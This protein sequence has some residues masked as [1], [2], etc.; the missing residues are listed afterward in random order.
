MKIIKT[1]SGGTQIKMSRNEWLKIG[2]A[3]GWEPPYSTNQDKGT[4]VGKHSTALNGEWEVEPDITRR[5][6]TPS[7]GTAMSV[8]QNRFIYELKKLVIGGPEGSKWLTE[9]R[10]QAAIN[11]FNTRTN[12]MYTIDAVRQSNGDYAVIKG[13]EAS[14][15][16]EDALKE[17]R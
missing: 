2:L 17:L 1:A 11:W 5:G 10:K 3:A 12:N 9:E 8:S 7:F 15:L 4:F 13:E 6:P 16:A 14:V